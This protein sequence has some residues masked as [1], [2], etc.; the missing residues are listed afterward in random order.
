LIVVLAGCG[1]SHA[2]KP[3][4]APLGDAPAGDAPAGD[5]PG[6]GATALAPPPFDW[7]GVIG[8]GQSLSI[9]ATSTAMS[10]SQPFHN[11]KLVDNGPA[12]KY[13]IDGSGAPVWATTPLIEP[14]RTGITGTGAGYT[15]GQYPNNTVGETPHSGMANALTALYA[16][17][18]GTQEYVS[19]HSVVGWSGHCLT[20][21]N[22]EGGQRAY[23]ASLVETQQFAKLAQAAGK[24][25]GVGGIIMTH[26]ECDATNP[27]YGAGLFTLWQDYNTDLKQITGQTRDVVMLVSQQSTEGV[28]NY[29]NSA[30]QVWQ[31]GVQHPG[32]IV[33]VGP[34]YQYAYSP[35]NLHFQAPGY[36]RLGEKYAE[37]F[38]AIV[39]RGVAW[40]P[41]QPNKIDRNGA[42]LTISFDVPSPPLA[43]DEHISMPH[44]TANTAWAAGRGFEVA[45]ANGAP[46][47]IQSV[48]IDGATVVLTL[49]AAPTGALTVAYAL[50]QDGSGLQ[51]GTDL[52][53]RGQLRDSDELIAQDA[54]T[55]EANVTAGSPVIT[56]VTAGGFAHRA[57]HDLVIADGSLP[58]DTIVQTFT[59]ASQLTL[60]ANWAGNSGTAQLAIH[61][62]L[63]NYCVQ[64]AMAVP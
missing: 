32:Q 54:E 23:P 15:D 1:G 36:Y 38:D 50:T 2:S 59:T 61:H 12:P 7:V 29:A 48:A 21:I 13:P 28:N 37:V 18:G 9:G 53:M 57:A 55:I 16:A 40:K 25:Y 19:A 39:N 3:V 27:A 64:F 56:S 26:G 11:L 52:G 42:V 41:L 60:S 58:A 24:T 44:Q 47:A 34:K 8:T 5:A 49:A 33:C 14:T 4:D 35:D 43:W 30:V 51:G 63:H 20:D 17:H 45:D 22:K 10:T 31:A 62:D 46:L 6:D